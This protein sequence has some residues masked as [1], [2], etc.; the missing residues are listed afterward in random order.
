MW[1]GGPTHL[2]HQPVVVELSCKFSS[3]P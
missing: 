3:S 2:T 1:V